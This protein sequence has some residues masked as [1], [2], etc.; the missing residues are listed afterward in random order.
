MRPLELAK[1]LRQIRPAP[2]NIL[3]PLS[4]VLFNDSLK[5]PIR[6]QAASAI[7]VLANVEPEKKMELAQRLI[8]S[9]KY[10]NIGLA[11]QI[12]GCGSTNFSVSSQTISLVKKHSDSLLEVQRMWVGPPIQL[13]EYPP[14]ENLQLLPG[15][16]WTAEEP[17]EKTVQELCHSIIKNR[18]NTPISIFNQLAWIL[19]PH[20]GIPRSETTCRLMEQTASVL[21]A[22]LSGQNEDIASATARALYHFDQQAHCILD[23]LENL[24]LKGSG[25]ADSILAHQNERAL[26]IVLRHLHHPESKIRNVCVELLGSFDGRRIPGGADTLEEAIRPLLGDPDPEVRFSAAA[27]LESIDRGDHQSY[28]IIIDSLLHPPWPDADSTTFVLLQDHFHQ[29]PISIQPLLMSIISDTSITDEVRY[30]A[31]R[32]LENMEIKDQ[33]SLAQMIRPWLIGENDEEYHIATRLLYD[34]DEGLEDLVPFFVQKL[35]E[36]NPKWVKR[37]LHVLRMIGEG[38]KGIFAAVSPYLKN[39]IYRSEAIQL[40]TYTYRRFT[41]PEMLDFL[42]MTILGRDRELARETAETLTYFSMFNPS[43]RDLLEE[44]IIKA[45]FEVQYKCALVFEGLILQ[46]V[47][48]KREQVKRIFSN[49]PDLLPKLDPTE[50]NYIHLHILDNVDGYPSRRGEFA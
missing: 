5:A 2:E 47:Q 26:P 38:E 21:V 48:G 42:R 31:A 18:E 3:L 14:F 15:L 27:A 16:P 46:G 22:L 45:D 50:G 13:E 19:E 43:V 41:P 34:V 32:G 36:G 17:T 11:I 25:Y 49:Y 39:E 6:G 4:E 35:T 33:D 1:I 8:E 44:T 9:G 20:Q 30:S 10:L 28:N 23:Q 7:G 40:L 12:I 24:L 29:A 37:A